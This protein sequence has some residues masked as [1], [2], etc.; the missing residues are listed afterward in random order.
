MLYNIFDRRFGS[1]SFP[2]RCIDR[3]LT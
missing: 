3:V 1:H 2:V